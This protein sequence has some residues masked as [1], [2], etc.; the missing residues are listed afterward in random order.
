MGLG[1]FVDGGWNTMDVGF[2][3][4]QTTMIGSQFKVFLYVGS[5]SVL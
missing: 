4:S 3:I 1:I 5:S 2:T